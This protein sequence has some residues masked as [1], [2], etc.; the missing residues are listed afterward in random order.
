[1]DHPKLSSKAR[2]W[3]IVLLAASVVLLGGLAIRERARA[4]HYRYLLNKTYEYA[5]AELST[6][7]SE[8]DAS[9]Q[10]GVYATSPQLFS[11]LC[12]DSFRSALAAQ[13]A[14]GSLP[15]GNVELEQT[16]A[17]LA[18]T[19][20]YAMS[21][22][23]SAAQGLTEDQRETLADLSQRA[24]SLDRTLQSLEQELYAGTV[25]LED[26]SQVQDRL[27]QAT[28][29]GQT[30]AGSSFQEIE[31]E[32][33]ELPT[34]IYD[35]PFSD[36]LAKRV[37][38]CLDGLAEISE[39]EAQARA[40]ALF[41]LPA[42]AFA[43]QSQSEGQIPTYGFAAQAAGGELYVELTRQG[44]AVLE[45]LTARPFGD[46]LLSREEAA[47]RAAAFLTRLGYADMAESY[48][49][50]QGTT[51][52]I[53]FAAKDGDVLCYPDQVKV[54]VALDDGTIAGFEAQNYLMAHQARDLPA[55]A[56]SEASAREQV[57]AGLEV[58]GHQLALIPT[59]GQDEV[60]CHEFKCQDA[61][62]RHYILYVDA[63][64]G[65]QERILILLEDESGTL[66]I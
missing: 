49:I 44:G 66:V 10:K 33:S 11:S 41:G 45:I 34:L 46:T 8:L 39:E 38:N 37:P 63:Q 36:H 13:T 19:G 7:V 65:E 21:L 6:S 35:G 24:A 31:R 15:Y 54:S 32:F 52:T 27:S 18:K 42:E 58:L 55:P 62:G 25:T 29:E 51:L 12:T 9:L 4:A 5:F 20:D 40:A 3:T 16:A 17:F 61:Q 14:L 26:L 64:T 53:H 43:L 50:D 28:E 1:M 2:I 30:T 22:S 47:A 56:V 23:R 57:T 59:A 48:F 60:L